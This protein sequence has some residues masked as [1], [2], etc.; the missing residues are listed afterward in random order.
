MLNPGEHVLGLAGDCLS[1][2]V[3]LLACVRIVVAGFFL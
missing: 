3:K 2:R 1:L